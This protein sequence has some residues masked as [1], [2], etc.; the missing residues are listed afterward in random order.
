ME[1]PT[2]DKLKHLQT[3]IYFFVLFPS[4]FSI[5]AVTG[6]QRKHMH[7]VF[8][9]PSHWSQD[10]EGLILRDS[11]WETLNTMVPR[12]LVPYSVASSIIFF[13]PNVLLF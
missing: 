9:P 12:W 10:H 4:R 1:V 11:H 7:I 3:V 13:L 5:V 2:G 8:S 6:G